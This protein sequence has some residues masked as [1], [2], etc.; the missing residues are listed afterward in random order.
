MS[1]FNE[2][3]GNRSSI[4]LSLAWG[5]A[6]SGMTFVTLCCVMFIRVINKE[7]IDYTGIAATIGALG[8]FIGTIIGAKAY[9][10]G[11]ES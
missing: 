10:K 5:M 7:P 3:N 2:D 4:R 8:I 11:K 1:A 6:F 9:Q